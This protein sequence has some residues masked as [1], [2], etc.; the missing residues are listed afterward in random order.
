MLDVL[1]TILAVMLRNVC[2]TELALSEVAVLIIN[3]DVSI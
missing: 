2:K 3:V 1:V